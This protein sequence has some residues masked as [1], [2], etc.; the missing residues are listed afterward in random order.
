MHRQIRL[1]PARAASTRLF[2]DASLLLTVREDSKDTE[3]K[4]L[5]HQD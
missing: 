4:P 1:V 2:A 5:F 3:I